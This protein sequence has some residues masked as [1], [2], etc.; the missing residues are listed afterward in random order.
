M[1]PFSGFSGFKGVAGVQAAPVQE[2][3]P[4]RS[5]QVFAQILQQLQGTKQA[6][7]IADKSKVDMLWPMGPAVKGKI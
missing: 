7:A 2:T 4:E 6:Q 3:E 1:T 5:T